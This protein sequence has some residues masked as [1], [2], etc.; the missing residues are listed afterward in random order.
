MQRADSACELGCDVH[1][2]VRSGVRM[3]VEVN[4]EDNHG[5]QPEGNEGRGPLPAF[6]GAS[7]RTPQTVACQ[8]SRTPRAEN[9]SEQPMYKNVYIGRYMAIATG[10]ASALQTP[11]RGIAW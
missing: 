11:D 9:S 6:R 3:K 7:T 10:G 4:R 5:P 1:G 8:I 2:G